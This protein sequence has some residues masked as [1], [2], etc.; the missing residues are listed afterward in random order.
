ML[1][2]CSC[3]KD[4]VDHNGDNIRQELTIVE[5][6]SNL[7]LQ[8]VTVTA[9]NCSA[10]G[11]QL[12]S[13][14]GD[15]LG[16]AITDDSGKVVFNT[17]GIGWLKLSKNHYWPVEV[18]GLLAAGN[19][20]ELTPIAT[21]KVRLKKINQ[22]SYPNGYALNLQSGFDGGCNYCLS[23]TKQLIQPG[24][25]IT[26]L[27]GVGLTTNFVMWQLDSGQIATGGP[28]PWTLTPSLMINRFD[29]A[30]FVVEY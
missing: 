8:G 29:T 22:N 17:P 26:Y 16:T 2:L 3:T 30:E 18:G 19:R 4:P 21:L 28:A 9:Y 25:G 14:P 27:K 13:G 11:W 24:D 10:S 20:F 7:P 5:T 1:A 6:S 15:F 23:Q 12:C